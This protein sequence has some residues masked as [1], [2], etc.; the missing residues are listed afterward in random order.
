M[1]VSHIVVMVVVG[2]VAF[3][4]VQKM[5]SRAMRGNV[6]D[7]VRKQM[8]ETR[9]QA[10][11]EHPDDPATVGMAKVAVAKGANDLASEPDATKRQRM[12]ADMFVGFYAANM[13]TRPAH[14]KK[15]GIDISPFT[16]A[17][18]S[19]HLAERARARAVYA[20]HPEVTEKAVA[21]A[22]RPQLYTI[23]MQDMIGLAA[24]AGGSAQEA[25]EYLN[26]NAKPLVEQMAFAKMQP[27]AR[28]A[29]MEP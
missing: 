26:N 9:Q 15:L 1:K 22:I 12:A 2:G 21:D 17:F 25:C 19:A 11:A 3:W 18:D 24:V 8:R 23:I 14:C 29:L 27:A 10:G 5:T 20:T 28:K 16:T 13:E 7:E 4:A 6:Q